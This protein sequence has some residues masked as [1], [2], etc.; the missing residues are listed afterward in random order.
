MP[1]TFFGLNISRS[2]LY[3]ASVNLNVTANNVANADTEGYSRQET[4]QVAKDALRVYQ[5]YGMIGAGVNVTSIDRVRDSFYDEKYWTNQSKLGSAEAKYYYEKQMENHLNEFE[6]DGFTK[7]YTNFFESLQELQKNPSDLSARTS[8]LSYGQS[9][10]TFLE[11]VKT[12]LRLEQEDIN[13]EVCDYVDKINTLASEAA[14][15]NKQINIIELTGASANELRDKRDLVIDELSQICEVQTEE[16]VWDN[17]KTEYKIMLGNNTL[18]DTYNTFK[19][20]VV[21]RDEKADDDDAVGLYDIYW[22]YNEE[23]NPVKLGLDGELSGLLMARDG[24]NNTPNEDS[25]TSYGIDYKG[26]TYY[27][28]EINRFQEAFANAINEI[29]EQGENLYGESTEGVPIFVKGEGNVWD[30]NP[31][32][33]ADPSKMATTYDMTSGVSSYDLAQDMLDLKDAKILE[34][35]TSEEFLQSI[36]TELGVEVK[37]QET[38]QTNY[39]NFQNVIQ[40]Q[41]LSVMGVDKDEEAM[42]LVKYQEAFDL[43]AKVMS[44]MQEIYDKLI[45]GTGV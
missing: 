30:V 15:L 1:S 10:M 7:E 40:N 20:K 21:T 26:I 42:N 8:V 18:V 14:V 33:L 6:V 34:N 16:K 27:I 38:L 41:R 39:E 43:N 3:A 25:D 24:N 22:D 45:N 44:V 28:N 37:K 4:T 13:A 2:G 29:H 12:N 23:L 9:M 11:Q 32:L 17:G 5:E 36:V 19:V 35:F 31:E